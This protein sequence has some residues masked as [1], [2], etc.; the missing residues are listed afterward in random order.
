MTT[1]F[2]D[3]ITAAMPEPERTLWN[4]LRSQGLVAHDGGGSSPPAVKSKPPKTVRRR[5]DQNDREG[6]EK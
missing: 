2:E 3:A 6:T 1:P 5:H 4:Y